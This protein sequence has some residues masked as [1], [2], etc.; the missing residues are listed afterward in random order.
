MKGDEQRE[1][2]LE[3]FMSALG[4]P[5]LLSDRD[6]TCIACNEAMCRSLGLTRDKVVGHTLEEIMEPS[7]AAVRGQHAL[8]VIQSGEAKSF[9]DSRG[10]RSF[11]IR[12]SPTRDSQGEITGLALYAMDIT[13]QKAAGKSAEAVEA[14]CQRIIETCAEGV[15]QI[16]TEH[17]TNFVNDQMAKMLGYTVDEFMGRS[18]YDFMDQEAIAIAENNIKRRQEGIE[19]RHPFR[20]RHKEGHA[21]WTAMST[22]PL[23]A[24]D[25]SYAGALAMV[26]DITE[27]RQLEQRLQQAEKLESLSV[28]AGEVAHDFNNVLAVILCNLEL[29]ESKA[30]TEK[31]NQSLIA[32]ILSAT[33]RA[34]DLTSQMLAFSGRARFAAERLDLNQVTE[35]VSKVFAG[36]VKRSTSLELQLAEEVAVIAADPAQIRRMLTTLLTNASDAIGEATAGKISVSTGLRDV[37]Q[38]TIDKTFLEC[39][40]VPGEHVFLRISDNGHGMSKDT[41]GRLFEPVFSTRFAGR[42]LGMAVVLGILRSHRAGILIDSQEGEGSQFE[43]LFPTSEVERQAAATPCAP[44]HDRLDLKGYVAV[45]DDDASFLEAV[46]AMLS[47]LGIEV[48]SFQSGQQAL[49]AI[50]SSTQPIA[51]ALVDMTMPGMSGSEVYAELRALYPSLPIVL[52]SGYSQE[53]SGSVGTDSCTA[54]LKK[55]YRL[56]QLVAAIAGATQK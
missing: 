44:K 26:T 7:A 11:S 16:D 49:D 35:E 55:P 56:P 38:E 3:L 37:S 17:K 32:G 27:Q 41:V 36:T 45:V 10:P 23:Q 6:L 25:G 4:H 1:G 53:V 9:E 46:S 30:G 19:E 14:R 50:A 40:L 54:F 48:L 8:E 28:L 21:V 51:A 22:N 24:E 43:I 29:I 47:A 52:S 33:E 42:G 13:Q 18:L 5:A 31:G 34:T 12:M 15:W 20:F 39:E 2:A